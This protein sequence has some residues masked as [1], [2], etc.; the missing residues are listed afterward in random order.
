M[1]GIKLCRL[2]VENLIHFCLSLISVIDLFSI[3]LLLQHILPTIRFVFLY[4]M[5]YVSWFPVF[6]YSFYSYWIPSTFNLWISHCLSFF[7]HLGLHFCI[8]N[9]FC[10]SIFR[11]CS[12]SSI[13]SCLLVCVRF[14]FFLF[15]FSPF[16]LLSLYF[17]ITV[18]PRC[19]FPF[20]P[21]PC[22]SL[23]LVTFLMRTFGI[24]I[25]IVIRT[26]LLQLFVPPLVS[27][28]FVSKVFS[29]YSV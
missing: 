3:H 17:P 16:I 29:T 26:L 27:Y 11:T 25:A 4:F 20:S 19:L 22:L 2:R 8:C 9:W 15:S 13:R 21:S 6:T 1:F 5:Y 7:S 28:I 10:I 24:H 23:S 14:A 12:L 18:L